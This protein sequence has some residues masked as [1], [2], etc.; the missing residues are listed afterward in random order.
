MSQFI[1]I[2]VFGFAIGLALISLAGVSNSAAES[3]EKKG[4]KIA[5]KMTDARDGFKGESFNAELILLSAKGDKITRKLVGKTLDKDN[6]GDRTLLTISWPPDVKG[7]KLLTWSHT[8]GS[9]D[10]WILLP[11]IRRV[12]RISAQ[13]KKGSF[14]GSEFSY[15]D[16]AS[17]E[18]EKYT[19]K[20]IKDGEVGGRPAWII[21]RYPVDKHSG[22]KKH[23]VW[24]DKQH[25]SE[26]KVDLYDRKGSLLKTALFVGYKRL[27]KLG[28][29]PAKIMVANHQTR[30]R[31][32]LQFS[33][34]VLGKEFAESSFEP[35]SLSD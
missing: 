34:H 6:D 15:E 26:L 7:T 11:S 22:Y 16:L 17:D 10:Q 9:D 32:V 31:S 25:F 33:D 2:K 21:E 20:Y 12:K 13:N 4:L 24:V 18:L 1:R 27:N 19:Y 14:M 35:N 23:V 30:K 3:A 8:R 29:R 28:W 5:K